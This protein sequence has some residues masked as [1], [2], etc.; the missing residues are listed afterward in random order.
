MLPSEPFLAVPGIGALGDL[1]RRRAKFPEHDR[2]PGLGF[3]EPLDDG[4]AVIKRWLRGEV[5]IHFK[6][7]LRASLPDSDDVYLCAD[8]QRLREGGRSVGGHDAIL[9]MSDLEDPTNGQGQNGLDVPVFV[10]VVEPLQ[11]AERMK[12]LA[13]RATDVRLMPTHH[14]NICTPDAGEHPAQAL[15][16]LSGARRDGELD[17]PLLPISEGMDG[18]LSAVGERPGNVIEGRSEVV[19]D[20]AEPESPFNRQR[21]NRSHAHGKGVTVRLVLRPNRDS[22]WSMEVIGESLDVGLQSVSVQTRPSPLS[23]GAIEGSH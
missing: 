10:T 13:G 2:D 9:L 4:D 6:L 1:D 7:G 21:R 17:S 15:V 16:E 19:G 5:Y 8:L 20:I 3:V 11:Y 18:P 14:C 12:M 22:W 23:P